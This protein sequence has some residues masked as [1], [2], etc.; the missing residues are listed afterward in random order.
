MMTM[1]TAPWL[2]PP[3][4]AERLHT[5]HRYASPSCLYEP[6]VDGFID[7]AARIFN[8]P[9]AFISLVDA[10]EVLYKANHGLPQLAQQPRIA[11]VCALTIRNNT[12]TLFTDL[13]QKTQQSCL[14]AAAALAVHESGV[15]FYASIPLRMP[16]QRPIGTLCIA[17]YCPRP[18]DA[19]EQRVLAQ[20]AGLVAQTLV[21]RQLCFASAWLGEEHWS[22]IQTTLTEDLWELAALVR[23]LLERAG[24]Q[25]PVPADVLMPVAR[26]LA[27]LHSTLVVHPGTVL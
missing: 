24:R 18:F 14:T 7:L 2:L 4:E 10:D 8:L 6:V 13:T 12:P 3:D 27:E 17:G 9:I 25:A 26:R 20:L 11:S 1:V 21:V 22:R 5:L 16:D 23:Y 19:A 15:Q